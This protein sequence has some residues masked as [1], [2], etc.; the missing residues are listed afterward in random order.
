MDESS[1]NNL[2]HCSTT[3]EQ[4]AQLHSSIIHKYFNNRLLSILYLGFASGLPLALTG[5]T[6][7]A[8]YTVS[9][10]N[11]IAI[12]F[13]GLLGQPYIYKFLW[14]PFLDRYIPPLLGR[15]RGWMLITQ[16]LLALTIA[17]MAL[18]Q[19][20]TSATTLALVALLVA[21]LSAT[22]DISIDAYRTEI[23]QPSERGIGTAMNVGGYRIAMLL[24]GGIALI[25]AAQLG[26]RATYFLMAGIMLFSC[27]ISYLAPEPEQTE[28]NPSSLKQAIMEPFREF[29]QR[30][31]ALALLAFIVL[32]KLGDAC[33]GTNSISTAFLIRGLGFSLIDVGTVNKTIGIIASLC[34]VFCGG[35][36]LSR[37]NI[38]KALWRFGILQALATFAFFLLAII[39]KNYNL[40]V[41]VVFFEN[42]T[43]GLLTAALVAFLMSLCNFRY[44][45][46]QFALLSAVAAIGRVVMGPAAGI[47]VA[48]LGWVNFFFCAFLLTLPG[49]A[50]L[51]YL[52]RCSGSR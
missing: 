30:D 42:F 16:L 4:S 52:R 17:W 40:M 21:F 24:S 9:G 1:N 44:T 46:T 14:A 51:Y 33:T 19:P 11:I 32:Y 20:T 45:A 41:T 35:I 39:G 48:Y 23:L 34:G 37:W 27:F 7:Q 13:L 2:T 38:F 47:T 5:T 12:G 43:A 18:L 8:W 3:V 50:L 26:W 36:L 28:E 15:R 25:M 6:L 29:M 49:L 10:V 22:Q 31:L